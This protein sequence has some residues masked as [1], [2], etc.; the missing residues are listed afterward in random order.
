VGL[1]FHEAELRK[2]WMVKPTAPIGWSPK[3][4]LTRWWTWGRVQKQTH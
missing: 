1:K 2:Y 3:S 4:K